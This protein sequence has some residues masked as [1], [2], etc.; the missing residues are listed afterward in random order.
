[1]ELEAIKIK[2]DEE[3]QN[4]VQNER[5]SSIDSWALQ[6]RLRRRVR[7]TLDLHYGLAKRDVPQDSAQTTRAQVVFR[8]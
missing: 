3:Q 4:Q 7:E 2:M 8:V 6:E 5:R 1:M